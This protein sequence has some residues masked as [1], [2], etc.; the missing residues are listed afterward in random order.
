M[1]SK[2]TLL[3]TM[4]YLALLVA[5]FVLPARVVAEFETGN[6]MEGAGTFVI[7]LLV[8]IMFVDAVRASRSYEIPKAGECLRDGEYYK[9]LQILDLSGIAGMVL[10]NPEGTRIACLHNF[11]LTGSLYVGRWYRVKFETAA[12][13]KRVLFTAVDPEDVPTVGTLEKGYRPQWST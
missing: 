7:W 1:F 8:I 13:A 11:W 3:D 12:D 2:K 10:Q 6:N 4:W 5:T 9:V